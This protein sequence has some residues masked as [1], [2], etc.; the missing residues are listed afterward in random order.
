MKRKDFQQLAALRLKEARVLLRSGCYEG[1]YYLGGYVAEY[2]LKGVHRQ[3]N[4][5]ARIPGQ[6]TS[7]CEL[8]ARHGG[9]AGTCPPKRCDHPRRG[10]ARRTQHKLE[11]RAKLEGRQPV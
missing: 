3:A 2:A 10:H 11:G 4:R 5:A 6:E 1:A 8:H 7:E 9:A